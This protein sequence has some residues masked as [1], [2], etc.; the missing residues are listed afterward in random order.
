MKT[1]FIVPFL[2]MACILTSGCASD[3]DAEKPGTGQNAEFKAEVMT[4]ANDY[5]LS[6]TFDDAFFNSR[7][8]EISL[9]RIDRIFRSAAMVKGTY[10][11]ASEKRR[12]GFVLSQMKKKGRRNRALSSAVERYDYDFDDYE[13]GSS[14]CYCTIHYSE[15]LSTGRFFDVDSEARVEDSHDIGT[16][17]TDDTNAYVDSLTGAIKVTG[18]VSVHY[19]SPS[20]TI[21]YHVDGYYDGSEGEITWR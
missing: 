11:V 19:N 2:I 21:K 15:D 5:G 16:S 17:C 20:M 10:F 12:G 6:V 14:V 13:S 7:T 18:S 1:D 8:N 4:M 3:S 9:E